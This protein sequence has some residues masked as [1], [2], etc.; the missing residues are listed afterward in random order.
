MTDRYDKKIK[1]VIDTDVGTDVDD[2]FALAYALKNPNLEVQAIS[3]VHGD[4]QVRAKIVRKLERILQVNIPIVAGKEGSSKYWTGIEERALS[5]EE[6]Q[7]PLENQDFPS[8]DANTRLVCIGPLTNINHQLEVRP[9]IREVR[10]IYVMGSHIGSHNIKTD[11]AAYFMV[12]AQD[13]KKYFITKEVSQKVT[14]TRSDLES[15]RGSALGDFLCESGLRWLEYSGKKELIMYDPLVV[16][17]AAQEGYVK[18]EPAN[19]ER[20]ELNCF[21]STDVDSS[22]KTKLL[23]A[24]RK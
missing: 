22:F 10:E 20:Q 8:Y 16:S 13:W 18:F 11:L 19:P 12:M 7:E 9:S 5:K 2:L 23:E 4:T 21:V 14:L 6:M 3:T 17:A 24:I 15:L 1:L